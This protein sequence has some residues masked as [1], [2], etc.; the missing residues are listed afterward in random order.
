MTPSGGAQ[1]RRRRDAA[2]GFGIALAAAAFALWAVPYGVVSPRSVR[3]LPL[4]PAFLPTVLAVCVGLLGLVCGLQAVLGHGAPEDADAPTPLRSDWA[5]GAAVIGAVLAAYV[6]LAEWLGM[7][8]LAV[9]ATAAL[10][11]AGGER[12]L[13]RGLAVSLLLPLGVFLFFTRV[14][15]VPLP[16]GFLEGWL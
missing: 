11:V 2:F 13:G 10:L 5:L 4:S 3:A 9:A 7:L 8:P 6:W 15:Q 16:L 1:R 12:S 14:A